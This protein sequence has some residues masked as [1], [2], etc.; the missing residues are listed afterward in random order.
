MHSVTL[1]SFY[2]GETVVT[3]AL[4]KAI[5]GSN[6]SYIQ[7]DIL[8]VENVIWNDCQEFIHKLNQVTGK[9]FRL[10]T[11]AE[12][13]YAARGGKR[14]KGYKYAG[15]NVIG[16]V[17]W[18]H[19]NSENKTHAVKTKLSNELGI[20]DMSGN[21]WEWCQ[22]WMDSYNSEPQVDPS[23]PINGFYRVLRG[24]SWCYGA[25]ICRVSFRLWLKPNPWDAI[26]GFRKPSLGDAIVGLRLVLPQ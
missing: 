6:P 24:G 20:F 18:H 22:D 14:S 23:G 2:I 11:E 1:S 10:P 12:W 16:D 15:S 7:G 21:V 3:Q 26:A 4:W 19:G 8:P 5:M 25:W 17:A 13:E 9:S